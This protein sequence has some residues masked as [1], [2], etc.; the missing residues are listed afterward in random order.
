MYTY[1]HN[2]EKITE[3]I[4]KYLHRNNIILIDSH[5]SI[6][7]ILL[8]HL[9]LNITKDNS[10]IYILFR[11]VFD[12]IPIKPSYALNHGENIFIRRVFRDEDL[13]SAIKLIP[14]EEENYDLIMILNPFKYIYEKTPS[15]AQS[16]INHIIMNIN[17]VTPLNKPLI[18]YNEH[19]KQ[20]YLCTKIKLIRH[21]TYIKVID[22]HNIYI[23]NKQFI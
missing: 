15:Y 23:E 13:I 3:I 20:D 5:I 2:L 9:V 8:N 22:T 4:D 10:Y 19:D 18:I 11:Q 17:L 6:L 21:D 1:Y 14:N 12:I 16:I 7:N